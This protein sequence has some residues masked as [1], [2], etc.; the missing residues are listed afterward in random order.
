MSGCEI[1]K[2]EDKLP[3]N[4]TFL[5]QSEQLLFIVKNFSRVLVNAVMNLRVP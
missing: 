5:T 2:S 4:V 1:L 3:F